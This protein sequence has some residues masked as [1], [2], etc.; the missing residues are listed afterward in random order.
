LDL[1][2]YNKLN[3]KFW[4]GVLRNEKRYSLIIRKKRYGAKGIHLKEMGPKY[5]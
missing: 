2:E 4:G 1:I 3:E 5:K